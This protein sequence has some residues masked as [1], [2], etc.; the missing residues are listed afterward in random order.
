MARFRWAIVL[1]LLAVLAAGCGVTAEQRRVREYEAFLRQSIG[2]FSTR[3]ERYSAAGMAAQ[4]SAAP[5]HGD[6][7]G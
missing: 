5:A 1:P 7:R 3:Y 2:D 6:S 4:E